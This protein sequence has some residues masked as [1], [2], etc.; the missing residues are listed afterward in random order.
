MGMESRNTIHDNGDVI[1]RHSTAWHGKDGAKDRILLQI[2]LT[3]APLQLRFYRRI[4]TPLSCSLLSSP[5]L[6]QNA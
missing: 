4:T 6:T 5:F 2:H 3:R 1:T